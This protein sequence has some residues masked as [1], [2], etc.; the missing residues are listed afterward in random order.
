MMER[1]EAG[2]KRDRAI[3]ERDQARGEV[4]SLVQQVEDFAKTIKNRQPRDR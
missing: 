1:D 2:M 3:S 4:T